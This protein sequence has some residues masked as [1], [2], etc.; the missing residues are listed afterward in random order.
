MSVEIKVPEMG[1]S[2]TEATIANWVKKEGDAVK[3]DEIL[4]E[5][6]TDKATMEVPAPSSGVL[7]KI[8]KKA[9]DT[10]K[11]K[12]IIGLIDSSATASAPSSSSPT[13]SAQTTQ[14]SGNDKTNDTLP[15]AVRK[16]IDDNGLNPAFISGSGKN[17]QITK[18]DVL[19]AIES[20]T[21]A[22]V[23]TAPVTAKAV[24]SPEIPKAIPAAR[25]TDLPR[26]NTVPMSRL[27][28]VIAERLVSAQH[29]AAILTTFN[30]VDMSYVME[31]RNR[32]KDKFKE[33]HNVGLGFMS[34]FT[35]AAIHALK[36]IPAINAEI[37]GNDIV[38][39]NY[40]DIGV[41]VGGPKGLVVPIV[42]DADLLSFAGIEQEI[43]RLANRVK[44]GK[45]ELAEMEGGTFTISNG[46]I[47][48]SMMSTPILNPPQ[49]GILGLHN[50]VKRAVVVNDQ[51]VIRPMMYLALSYDHRIVDGKEA[52]TFLVKVKEAI[53]DP[54][55]LLLEL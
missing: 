2:I 27:R 6:E 39:K 7:Q 17:G 44:D 25:R 47:Y 15:P 4:L 43:G 36:T 28:K 16:L 23:A 32:Y 20:K 3:Q 10:V 11:V 19:K 21:S 29:N 31:L 13:T 34:F 55:R 45:I 41:A 35:K 37:R 38:Y 46:G 22:S 18:E 8:H 40:F 51:I 9:G 5:L 12:E 24:S 26:E 48:G 52:V 1:E 50:I 53:E 54:A 33:T 42:R 30:E 14:T 49:S